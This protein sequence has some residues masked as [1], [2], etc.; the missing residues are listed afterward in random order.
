MRSYSSFRFN[1]SNKRSSLKYRWN[2]NSQKTKPFNTIFNTSY[3]SILK[4]NSHHEC[5][6]SF[7]LKLVP[8]GSLP[9]SSIPSVCV[10]EKL[11]KE[12]GQRSGSDRWEHLVC[13]QFS[14]SLTRVVSQG[15][16][17]RDKQSYYFALLHEYKNN[18]IF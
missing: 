16:P 10:W 12:M 11:C 8:S 17:K 1:I 6:R 15:Y 7:H 2:I 9:F 13:R 3:N 5:T 18:F 4:M 14:E